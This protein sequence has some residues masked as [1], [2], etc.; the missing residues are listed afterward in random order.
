[1][2]VNGPGQPSS[3]PAPADGKKPARPAIKVEE[4]V[5]AAAMALIFLISISNVVVR[6]AT[7]ISFA[8]TEEFSVFLLVFMTFVGASLAVAT[9]GHIRITFFRDRMGPR[10]RLLCDGLSLLASTALFSLI[11]W[12]GTILTLDDLYWGETSPGLGLPRWIYTVWLPLLSVVIVIRLL[13]KLWRLRI[14]PRAS[15]PDGNGAT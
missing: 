13:L 14:E 4:A 12:H 3:H 1:M 7:D 5:G 2:T 8:F 15:T 10:R 9:D 6:Y 11:V